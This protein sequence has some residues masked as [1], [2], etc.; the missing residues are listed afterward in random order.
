MKARAGCIPCF[1]HQAVEALE[2]CDADHETSIRTMQRLIVYTSQVDFDLSPPEISLHIHRIIREETGNPDPYRQVKRL[3]TE[4]VNALLPEL[5][6]LM[7]HTDD[8]LAL[9]VKIGALGNVMDFGTPI[10]MDI[11]E[12]IR[13]TLGSD[14]TIFDIREFRREVEG[15]RHILF[16]GDNAG[17]IVLDTFL[18][19]ELAGA[20]NRGERSIT[21][22]V[23]EG[24]IINDAT[25]VEAREAGID[26]YATVITT[27]SQAPGTL[28]SHATP[29]LV[30]ALRQADLI[31]SKGQGNYESLSSDPLLAT[32]VRGGVPVYFLL[33]VKCPIVGAYAGVPEGST[34]FRRMVP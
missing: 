8:P 17:E 31:V 25:M 26:R 10:R 30:H 22:G 33:T 19:S 7:E 18:L 28:L 4:T 16:L 32:L 14:L 23:R 24:P 11:T 21:Y 2:L 27:G 3:S 15:A 5:H 12:K 1:L 34:I 6:G 13:D 29:D 20:G 9:A